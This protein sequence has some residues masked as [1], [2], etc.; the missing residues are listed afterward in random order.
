MIEQV[1][2]L[3]ANITGESRTF[4]DMII[5]ETSVLESMN[6]LLASPTI[7]K[8]L[9]KCICWLTSNIARFKCLSPD[10]VTFY[11]II[12]LELNDY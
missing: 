6:R 3:I 1:L 7:S 4:R 2:W 12:L 11:R 9:F 5:H 8:S 10:E